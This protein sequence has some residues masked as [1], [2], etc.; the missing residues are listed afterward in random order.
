[1]MSQ[2]RKLLSEGGGWGTGVQSITILGRRSSS[3]R[4]TTSDTL[5]SGVHCE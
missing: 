3:R 1:M 2:M 4:A 5:S